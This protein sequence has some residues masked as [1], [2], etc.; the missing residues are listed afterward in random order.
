[1]E[2]VGI[3]RLQLETINRVAAC[4]QLAISVT[5]RHSCT[6]KQRRR[7]TWTNASADEKKCK[8]PVLASDVLS[9][10]KTT[11]IALESPSGSD[12]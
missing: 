3:G 2:M 10:M 5:T 12:T 7:M 6:L 11:L 9:E 4:A 8:A 1:M